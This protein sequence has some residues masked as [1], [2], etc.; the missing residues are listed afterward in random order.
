[1]SKEKEEVVPEV[2]KPIELDIVNE[3]VDLKITTW[4]L[5]TLLQALAACR[6]PGTHID[7]VHKLIEKLRNKIKG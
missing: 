5:D 4:E 7:V 3:T 1:M 2:A 6:F